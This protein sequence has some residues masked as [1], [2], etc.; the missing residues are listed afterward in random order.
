MAIH[1]VVNMYMICILNFLWPILDR[2]LRCTKYDWHSKLKFP[3][4]QIFISSNPQIFKFSNSPV[5]LKGFRFWGLGVRESTMYNLL[6]IVKFLHPQ[7]FK[8]PHFQIF[9]FSN[10]HILKS[11]HPQIFTSS[12]SLIFKFPHFQIFKFS[13]PQISKSSKIIKCIVLSG[14]GFRG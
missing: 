12:I 9:K 13:H 10:F 8:F 4:L 14:L 5:S 11:P 1:G 6:F 7:I 3:H 2:N